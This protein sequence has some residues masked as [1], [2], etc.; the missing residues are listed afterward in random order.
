MEQLL[1]LLQGRKKIH[2]NT[3]FWGVVLVVLSFSGMCS[4]EFL[5]KCLVLLTTSKMIGKSCSNRCRRENNTERKITQ[6]G[7][8]VLSFRSCFGGCSC[9]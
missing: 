7:E 4:F 9:H 6:V 2:K 1:V 3:E 8:I 5:I